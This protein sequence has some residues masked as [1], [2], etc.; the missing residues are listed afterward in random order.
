MLIPSKVPAM[1]I[2]NKEYSRKAVNDFIGKISFLYRLLCRNFSF[3]YIDDRAN[4]GG[5]AL[6]KPPAA[7][8]F[9]VHKRTIFSAG[10]H[11]KFHLYSDILQH[12]RL[13]LIVDQF[14]YGKG[15]GQ[16]LMRVSAD[17]CE[18]RIGIYKF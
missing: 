4:N 10:P 15:F 7:K 11:F 1:L 12:H 2:Q 5:L 18:F 17:L 16:F 6:V 9:S 8:N 14:Y 13:V 3:G